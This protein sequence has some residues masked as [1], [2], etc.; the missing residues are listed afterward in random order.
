[1]QP[2]L[3]TG[4]LR[5]NNALVRGL[6]SPL[7][8]SKGKDCEIYIGEVPPVE[9]GWNGPMSKAEPRTFYAGILQ[10]TCFAW[11]HAVHGA[12]YDLYQVHDGIKEGDTFEATHPVTGD[13][14]LF[15]AESFHI[16][17][18]AGDPGPPDGEV[19]TS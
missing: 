12:L 9:A 7:R 10:H 14:A 8:S 15:K 11:Q 3:A 17:I 13:V 18:T 16:F 1:M 4:V 6:P 2:W 5:I 19:S